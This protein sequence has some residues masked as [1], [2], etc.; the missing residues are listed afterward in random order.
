M[1]RQLDSIVVIDVE[2]T[3]WRNGPP[4]GQE[5]EIIEIGIAVL[6]VHSHEISGRDAILVKPE[7]SRV[8]D[9]CE[10]LTSLT[11]EVLDRE[12]I[13]F[14]D[15][16]AKLAETYSTRTRTWASYGSYDRKM[17][18]RQ[19]L[20]RAVKYPF[21]A[22]HLCLKNLFA[23]TQRLR[24]EVGMSTALRRAGLELQGRHHRGVDDAYNAAK[25]LAWLLS[26]NPRPD[27]C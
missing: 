4:A 26:G 17:F 22:T 12:G 2:S 5:S 27:D 23:L 11:Q 1:A 7:R 21:G 20:E 18:E 25:L 9:F 14:A 3:C 15:A 6:D 16:C 8:S 13:A 10:E 24:R 19:C